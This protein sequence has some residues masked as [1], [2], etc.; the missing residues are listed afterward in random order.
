MS[1]P[2]KTT[3]REFIRTS[4]A[5]AA[6]GVVAARAGSMPTTAAGMRRVIGANDRINVGHVGIGVQGMTHVRL[7]HENAT[8]GL[9]NNTQ[10]IAVCDIYVRA[11]KQGQALLGLQD[12]QAYNDHRK[13]LE[14]KDIDAVWVTTSDN[15]HAPIALDALNAGKH[16]YVEKPMCKTLEENFALYDAVKN[17]KKVLQVGS[18]GCTDAKWHVAGNVV[19]AGK[20]GHV[21]LG[22]GSYMRN[23]KVGEWND[24]KKIDKDASPT[25]SGDGYINWDVFRRGKGPKDWDPDRYFRWRKWW[26]YGSGVIGDL[27]P[28][29]LHPLFIAMNLPTDGLNGFPV[30][31]SSN[32]GLYVQ[33]INPDTGKL[34][35]EVPDF[36]TI[37]VDFGDCTMI[38]MSSTI[39]EQ[40][41]PDCIR[42]NKATLYFGGNGVEIKPERVWSDEIDESTEPVNGPK[43]DITLHEKNFLDCIRTNGVPNC[44]IDIAVRV[45]TM[46]SLAERSY[47]ESKM[48]TFD[49]KTRRAIG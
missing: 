19:K 14:V 45:Q 42:G 22:Q 25:A 35:R 16:V 18:Q 21:V 1:D 6:A 49:P 47:R 27:F 29:R 5:V 23:G 31:V 30:R 43:E 13:M 38:A 26:D 17:T 11:K 24:Y 12:S 2:Q 44:N 7:L 46:I 39:N 37:T 3:R 32:G 36:N 48:F 15:W 40:G 20:I 33:K 34:D 41:W 10:Q 9:K 4:A 8:D 28:H